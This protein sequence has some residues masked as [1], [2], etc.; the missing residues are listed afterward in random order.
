MRTAAV[1]VSANVVGEM[2]GSERPDEIVLLGCHLDSWDLGTG[3]IDDGAGCAIV[4]AAAAH[5][6]AWAGAPKRTLRVV[7]YANEEQGLWGANAYHAAHATTL[8]RHIIGAESDFGAG[9]IYRFSTRI[10]PEAFAIADQIMQ[11]LA[12][13]GIV[14]GDNRAGGGA[15]LTPLRKA[16]MAVATLHQDGTDY[17]DYHHTANDTLDKIDPANLAQNVAAYLVFAFL[18]TSYQGDFGFDLEPPEAVS[19]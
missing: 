10:K 17:F 15:D 16:G 12:P 3:A 2:T 11:V 4:M 1:Y 19:D 6:R 8:D 5:L 13:L 14:R 9:R 18:T 7:L